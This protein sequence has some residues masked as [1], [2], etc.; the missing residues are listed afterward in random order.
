VNPSAESLTFPKAARLLARREFLFLQQ[1]GKKLHG[2]HFL[3]ITAPG[4][5]HRSRLGLTT[6]RRFGKA[7]VRN[8]M[9][10]LLREF[11]RERQYMIFPA[12]DI[13]I[14]PKAGA[15]QLSLPQI[16]GELEGLIS[17]AKHTTLTI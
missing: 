3:V 8:R 15:S 2:P 7:V 5:T 17:L 6:S 11:F 16:A 4:R 1:R 14:I 12:I 10:R 9:K 13:I